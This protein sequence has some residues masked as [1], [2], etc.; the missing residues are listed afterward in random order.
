ME[1]VRATA[2]ATTDTVIVATVVAIE[3]AAATPSPAAVF[4][5]VGSYALHRCRKASCRSRAD[6]IG[7]AQTR[8]NVIG[9]RFYERRTTTEDLMA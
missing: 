3:A 5:P 1:R 9:V 2:S 7:D 4:D 8:N 6:Q